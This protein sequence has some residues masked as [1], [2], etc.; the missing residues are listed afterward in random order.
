MGNQENMA[1]SIDSSGQERRPHWAVKIGQI[2]LAAPVVLIMASALIKDPG[3]I[4]EQS[5]AS[6][7][8]MV[9]FVVIATLV[10]GLMVGVWVL[11]TF[12][13]RTPVMVAQVCVVWIGGFLYQ[14]GIR[15]EVTAWDVA[16]DVFLLATTL[17]Q[18]IPGSRH[19]RRPGDPVSPG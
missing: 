7:M 12:R 14:Q 6:G 4:G 1:R 3:R 13:L 15:Q 9:F 16:E 8:P 5:S 18:L 2:G 17:V 11:S 10:S 19:P